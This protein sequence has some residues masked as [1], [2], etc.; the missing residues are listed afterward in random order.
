MPKQPNINVL[1]MIQNTL[2]TTQQHSDS[3]NTRGLHSNALATV[4][5]WPCNLIATPWKSHTI[6][7]CIATPWQWLRTKKL[8]TKGVVRFSIALRNS[9][10]EFQSFQSESARFAWEWKSSPHIFCLNSPTEQQ[11]ATSFENDFCV[12]SAWY[13]ATLITIDSIDIFAEM[14]PHLNSLETQLKTP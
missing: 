14:W 8:N 7:Y 3:H 11:K 1:A 9:V 5:Q 10:G 2:A 12:S 4:Y 6:P 13:I